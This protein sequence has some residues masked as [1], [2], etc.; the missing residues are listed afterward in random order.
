MSPRIFLGTSGWNYPHWAGV[1]YPER[2]PRSKW[3]Q[4]YG[5]HF[6]TVEV[7]ATFYRLPKP[8][9][10]E[11]WRRGTPE[12]FLWAVKASRYITHVKKMR[13]T[14]DPL[15]RFLDAAEL[16]EQ[17]LGPVLFQLPP[18]LA[19]DGVIFR[20]FCAE[21]E[22]RRHRYALEVRHGSWLADEALGIM[23]DCNIALCIADTAGRFPYHEHLTADFT[24]IRLH[25]SRQLYASS[26]SDVELQDW[27]KKIR[28]WDRD[29]YLYFDN[30]YEGNA[31]R[32]ALQLKT[33]LLPG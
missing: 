10:F 23:R 31:P 18:F 7:N 13:D 22:K 17:K 29:T 5:E 11:K 9:T 20:D 25:G 21:L 24:Y 6:D 3:L 2:A 4:L 28:A 1:F 8:E 16:L 27:A 30:D 32:N 15:N 33:L 14:R 12:G 19:F 26:Y